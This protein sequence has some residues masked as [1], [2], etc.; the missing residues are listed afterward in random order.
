MKTP[1]VGGVNLISDKSPSPSNIRVR[2]ECDRLMKRVGICDGQGGN[3]RTTPPTIECRQSS[4]AAET[5]NCDSS[6][7]SVTSQ[8]EMAW[9]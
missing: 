4:T 8:L 5:V 7:Q 2:A 9:M 6:W 3:G 1:Y